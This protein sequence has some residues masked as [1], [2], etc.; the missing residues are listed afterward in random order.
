MNVNC[1]LVM[2]KKVVELTK[3]EESSFKKFLGYKLIV[4]LFLLLQRIRKQ[5]L[6]PWLK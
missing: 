4:F 3:I 1:V 6:S 2:L 5:K